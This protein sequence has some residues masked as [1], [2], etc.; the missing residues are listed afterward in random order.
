MVIIYC[1][2]GNSRIDNN[3]GNTLAHR[4]KSGNNGK[5]QTFVE[6]PFQRSQWFPGL[7]PLPDPVLMD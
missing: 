7:L 6:T 1:D 3:K 5:Q 4:A 2:P